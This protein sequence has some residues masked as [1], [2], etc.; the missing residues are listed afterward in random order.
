MGTRRSGNRS[1]RAG[2]AVAVATG[3]SRVWSNLAAGIIGNEAN[4]ANWM[5]A[6]VLAVAV[7]GSVIARFRARGMGIVLVATAISQA[8]VAVIALITNLG[9]I[10]YLTAAWML[11]WL[12][13]AALFLRAS[14]QRP[15]PN[16]SPFAAIGLSARTQSMAALCKKPDESR[17]FSYAR[18]LE[19]CGT[20]GIATL[21]AA[22]AK[23]FGKPAH[24]LLAGPMREGIG[25][26]APA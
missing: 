16:S 26:N 8:L 22:A 5:F 3:F 18:R 7:I 14:K 24:T 11:L 21:E 20:E 1:Y 9:N 6:G 17:A 2:V 23:S 15:T 4:P 25:H 19:S 12:S 13:S 10:W